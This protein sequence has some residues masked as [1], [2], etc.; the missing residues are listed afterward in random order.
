MDSPKESR[1]DPE[2][3]KVYVTEKGAPYVDVNELMRSKSGRAAVK[4][5]A[6]IPVTRPNPK[7]NND[8]SP[9]E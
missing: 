6:A 1:D 4:A 9:R 3:P 2:R 8:N 5:A 7:T